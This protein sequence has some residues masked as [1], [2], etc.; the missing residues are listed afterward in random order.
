MKKKRNV[1]LIAIV[2]ALC[3][4]L[5]SGPAV[6]LAQATEDIEGH[7]AEE[8]IIRW[9]DRGIVK[10]YED[11]TFGP[12]RFIKRAEFAALLNRTF[13]YATVSSIEF[14]DVSNGDWFAADVAK[15]V[16][17]GYMK[18]YDDG[19]FR[20]DD[21]ITRQEA[22]LVFAR[23]YELEQT[24]DTYDFTDFDSLPDWSRWAVVAVAKA[25]LMTGYPDGRF[26]PT[27]NLKRAETVTV[28]D[29]LVA[30]I[31]TEEGTYGSPDEE[32]V[33]DGNVIV[34]AGDVTLVNFRITGN[35]L[36]AESVGEGTVTLAKVTVDGELLIRGGGSDSIVLAN[37]TV[38]TLIIDKEGVRVVILE[39]TQVTEA[40]VRVPSMVEQDAEGEGIKA[41]IVEE[42]LGDGEVVLSG[43]FASVSIRVESGKIVVEGGHIDEITVESTAADVVLE[44]GSDVSV[45]N[46]VMDAP[47]TVGGTGTIETATVNASGAVIEQQPEEVVLGEDVTAIIAG[48]EVAYAPPV[49]IPD[50]PYF[51]PEEPEA[52]SAIS[53]EGVAKVGET[54]TAKVTPSGATVNYKWQRSASEDKISEF[55][56]IPGATA[57]TYVLTEDDLDRWIKV[58]VTGT[59]NYTGTMTSNAVGLVEAAEEEP[60]ELIEYASTA[61]ADFDITVDFGTEE[62]AAIA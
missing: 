6:L 7:W 57:K 53:V 24:G 20:P 55:S 41:L 35:L 14:P 5:G 50:K 8:A 39:G 43:D 31:F 59:G 12:D 58:E 45:A 46:L 16:G 29:R 1:R 62:S 17:A 33:I 27:G 34:T 15:A 54:L 61:D 13:G 4:F 2:L 10:G 11:G 19:T 21:F 22:A 32:T 52:V 23:I 36:I 49:D 30:G 51:P 3:M 44:L 48:E 56:D 42:I 40:Y 9:V 26:A 38:V 28:L 25:G 37:T 47:A 18:G 60:D